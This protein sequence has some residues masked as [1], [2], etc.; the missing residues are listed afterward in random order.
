MN[1][2]QLNAARK[3]GVRHPLMN[4]KDADDIKSGLVRIVDNEYYSVAKLTHSISYLTAGAA[5]LLDKMKKLLRFIGEQRIE[6][7]QDY[8]NLCA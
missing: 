6:S 3:L 1:D 2:V 4:R 5:E 8:C 7:Q